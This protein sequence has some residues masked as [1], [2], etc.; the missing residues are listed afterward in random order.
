MMTGS[1]KE[2]E[3]RSAFDFSPNNFLN[4]LFWVSKTVLLSPRF[5]FQGMKREGGLQNPFL[6]LVSCVIIHSLMNGL[7]VGKANLVALNLL[8]GTLFPFITAGILFLVITKLLKAPGTYEAVFRVNAYA[9]ALSLLSWMPLVGMIL[10]LY[11]VYLIGVGLSLTF[12]IKAS[13]AFLAVLLTIFIYIAAS[14][15]LHAITGGQWFQAVS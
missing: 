7:L 15:A 10:E 11:R 13:Q 9:A 14:F 6:Y 1:E 2:L 12:S 3:Q 5:F 8:F 4:S